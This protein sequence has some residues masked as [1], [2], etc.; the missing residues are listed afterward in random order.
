MGENET[1]ISFASK[2]GGIKSKFKS[3]GTTI[4]DKKIV[5]NFLIS[6]PK[7]F[8]PIVASIKQYSEIDKMTFEEAVG[9]ITAFEER[10]KSQNEPENNNLL[11]ASSDNHSGNWHHG[12][13][14]S[15][16]NHG[17]GRG[18]SSF[19]G[20]RGCGRNIDRGNRDKSEFQCYECGEFRHF[21]YECSKRKDEEKRDEEAHLGLEEEPMLL[22]VKQ[23][24][25]LQQLKDVRD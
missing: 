10:L 15:D 25:D 1:I 17:R 12:K 19:R 2:L 20:G 8:L 6:V 5:R 9:R 14:R 22:Q 18:G 16:Q 13:G 4:K 24:E 3:L 23:V 11:M 7:K 21:A